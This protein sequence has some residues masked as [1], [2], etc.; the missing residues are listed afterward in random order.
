MYDLSILIPT[1]NRPETAA[2]VINGLLSLKFKHNI[3]IVVS[4]NSDTNELERIIDIN[5]L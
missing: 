2:L 5:R 3:Q 1:R 4:D